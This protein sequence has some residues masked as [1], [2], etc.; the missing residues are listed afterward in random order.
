MATQSPRTTTASIR[1]GPDELAAWRSA[2]ESAGMS[3]S[4]WLRVQIGGSALR[5]PP[6]RRNQ[7]DPALLHQLHRIGLN[8]NQL[9]KVAHASGAQALPTLAQLAEIQQ[10]LRRL[11]AP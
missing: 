10:E 3:L 7:A 8:L 11:S 5:T 6:T 1:L 4:D 2:A 9:A